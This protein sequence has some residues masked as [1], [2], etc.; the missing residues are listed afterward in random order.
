MDHLTV[1]EIIDFVSLTDLGEESLKLAAA[2][3]GH[4]RGCRECRKLVG[5]FQTVH[6]EFSR[7]QTG[8]SF[9]HHVKECKN[10]DLQSFLEES[11]GFDVYK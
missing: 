3:N 9:K 10:D 8:V 2:V 4:M 1:D 7:L 6:D 5:A 11:E